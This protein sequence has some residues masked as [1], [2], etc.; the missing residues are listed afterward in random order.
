MEKVSVFEISSMESLLFRGQFDPPIISQRGKPRNWVN[1]CPD[2]QN[3]HRDFI[4]L[5][6]LELVTPDNRNTRNQQLE[7][8]NDRADNILVFNRREGRKKKKKKKTIEWMWIR[9]T[10]M[11]TFERANPPSRISTPRE[12]KGFEKASPTPS[13]ERS[14]ESVN[15]FSIKI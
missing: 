12:R 3:F 9:D 10:S 6:L 7:T 5:P 2:T 14:N 11:L 13:F 15:N 1:G 8:S 4:K